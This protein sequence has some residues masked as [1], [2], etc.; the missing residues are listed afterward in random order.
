MVR[1]KPHPNSAGGME[2]AHADGPTHVWVRS[3][4]AL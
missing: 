2:G 4:S 3:K 1:S